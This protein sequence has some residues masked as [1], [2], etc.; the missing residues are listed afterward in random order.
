M[1]ND[2]SEG[3]NKALNK[4]FLQIRIYRREPEA[5]EIFME[6]EEESCL[7][8]TILYIIFEETDRL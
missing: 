8:V 5:D 4:Y 7:D 2:T 6:E 1:V 3:A